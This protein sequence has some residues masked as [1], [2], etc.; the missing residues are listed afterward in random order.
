MGY[1]GLKNY[2]PKGYRN[3]YEFIDYIPQ[4][5]SNTI[6][7]KF[8]GYL[9]TFNKNEFGE[10]SPLILQIGENNIEICTKEDEEIS[11]TKNEIDLKEPIIWWENENWIWQNHGIELLDSIDHNSKLDSIKVVGLDYRNHGI[12]IH[13]L[14][15]TFNKQGKIK[16]IFI[17]TNFEMTN[18]HQFQ[19]L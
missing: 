19:K 7:A 5:L 12:A 3:I 16:E 1:V 4:I 6:G 11:L 14:I 18:Q 9:A 13:G 10:N 17:R 15:F 8:K 2:I